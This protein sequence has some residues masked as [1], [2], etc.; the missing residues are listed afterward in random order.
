[1][2]YDSIPQQ[3]QA[4]GLAGAIVLFAMVT[5]CGLTMFSVSATAATTPPAGAPVWIEAQGEAAGSEYDPPKEVMERARN[6]ARRKAV[7]QAV[8][9]FVRSQ[10]LVANNEL[11]E[12]FTYARVRGRIDKVQ[13]LR[14]E[15]DRNDPNLYRCWLKALVQPVYPQ[16]GEGISIKLDLSKTSL[17]QGEEVKILYQTNVDCYIHIFAIG[18]DNSVTLLFPNSLAKDN[19]IRGNSGQVFPPD[20]FPVK[21]RAQALPG[22]QGERAREKV[23]IIATRQKEILLERGFAEGLFT[24]YDARS[25]GLVGD[26]ARKLNQLEPADWGEAVAVY[27][28]EP[29]HPDRQ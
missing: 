25:T 8:G 19:F 9:A 13:I 4:T 6:E 26:L 22:K 27:T 2:K 7:E 12:E 5:T 29:A 11:A 28:I 16:E 20:A 23:K 24:T 3:R 10:A 1:M 14:E 15:R 18:A 17:Q 21:L